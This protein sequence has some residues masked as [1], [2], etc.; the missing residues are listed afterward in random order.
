[1]KLIMES[2]RKFLKEAEADEET[3]PTKPKA[4]YMA[5]GPGS[6]KSTVLKGLGLKGKIPIINADA[7]Y[8]AGLKDAGL[9]LGGKPEVYTRIKELKAELENQS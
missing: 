4:I 6:G 9:S 5:G 1:M 8:E 7:T 2:W 3:I